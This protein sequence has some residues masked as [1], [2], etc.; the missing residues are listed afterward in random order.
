MREVVH[1]SEDIG[2]VIGTD[3][4]YV[5][6]LSGGLSMSAHPATFEQTGYILSAGIQDSAATADG[7]GYV[8]LHTMPTTAVN[9]TKTYTLEGGDDQEAERLEYAYV[10]SFSL[11]GKSKE[12]LQLS[13]EW[14]GR[15]IALNAFT[16]TASIPNVEEIL[17]QKCKLYID[18]VTTHPATTQKA[19]SML[20]F[21]LSVNTGW[22]ENYTGDGNLYFSNLRFDGDA[23]EML[24][25]VTFEHNS[26]AAAEKVAWRAGTARSIK[27]LCEGSALLT[28]GTYS[29]KSLV[30]NLLGKWEKFTELDSIDGNDI[31]TGTLRCRYDPTAASAGSII[32]VNDLAALA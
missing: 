2:I 1:P 28:P 6:Y 13:A 31:V 23:F 8:Y 19:L 32:I 15:Q 9:T 25:D 10:K 5:P 11:S 24:L 16:A 29:Y 14:G 27:L 30:V 21:A 3:R 18:A 7:S 17:F 22:S 26:V 12:A 4:A 20:S